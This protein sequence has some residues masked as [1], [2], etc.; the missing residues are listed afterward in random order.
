VWYFR[1]KIKYLFFVSAI[2]LTG[3]ALFDL[4]PESFEIF[5]EAGK[6]NPWYLPVIG[7]LVYFIISKIPSFGH[8]HKSDEP[9]N[10]HADFKVSSII[11]HSVIDGVAIGAALSGSFALGVAILSASLIHRFNDGM[12]IVSIIYGEER[13]LKK[14]IQFLILDCL[15][16]VVGVCI[17]ILF[18]IKEGDL[19]Y[20]IGLLAGAFLYIGLVELLPES[21]KKFGRHNNHAH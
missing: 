9:K 11:I 2:A 10:L 6:A 14:A 15:A 7:F 21:L 17:S 3:V 13:N 18:T 16:P 12:N 19:G 20:I 1:S 8:K 5:K 4:I